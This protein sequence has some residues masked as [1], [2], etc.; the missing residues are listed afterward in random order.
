MNIVNC[1]G[2]KDSVAM[3]AG[4]LDNRCCIAS[5]GYGDGSY[6]CYVARDPEGKIVAATL[7]FI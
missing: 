6:D 3:H 4:I 5:S 1:S 2:G 7:K